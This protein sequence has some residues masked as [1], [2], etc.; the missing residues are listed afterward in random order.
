M[1]RY[2]VGQH[3]FDQEFVRIVFELESDPQVQQLITD[4]AVRILMSKQMSSIH[5][6]QHLLA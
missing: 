4:H 1:D 5:F 3:E 2:F 6:L